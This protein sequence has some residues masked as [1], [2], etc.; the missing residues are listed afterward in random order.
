MCRW[1]SAFVLLC[2][3][4]KILLSVCNFVFFIIFLQEKTGS[5]HYS[6]TCRAFLI[7]LDEPKNGG[8]AHLFTLIH[9]KWKLNR[10][11]AFWKIFVFLTGS[12]L[13]VFRLRS[14]VHALRVHSWPNLNW[15]LHNSRNSN[16]TQKRGNA[17]PREFEYSREKKVHYAVVFNYNRHTGPSVAYTHTNNNPSHTAQ[18][19]KSVLS[20]VPHQT[21]W[22]ISTHFYLYVC[23]DLRY[24]N[25]LCAARWFIRVIFT[26]TS[27]WSTTIVFFLYNISRSLHKLWYLLYNRLYGTG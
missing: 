4:I 14:T 2:V 23:S 19:K 25:S 21:I 18:D 22:T 3:I 15:K 9:S 5:F 13:I 24:Y 12:R 16:E 11:N 10:S 26:C 6:T 1:A 27:K 17:T 7:C 20:A 8:P